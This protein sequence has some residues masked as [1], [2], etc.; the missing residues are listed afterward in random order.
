MR[1]WLK[2]NGPVDNE[3]LE[4]HDKWLCMMWP[5]LHLLRELLSEDG[6]IFVSID[7]HEQHHLRAIMDEIFGAENFV[8]NVAVVS[9]LAG[10]SDQFGFAGAHE[11]C[12]VYAKY[13]AQT[14]LGRFPLDEDKIAEWDQD[15]KG[16]YKPELLQRSSL[17]FSASL[18]YPIFVDDNGNIVVTDEDSY[19]TRSVEY[20]A[21]YPVTRNGK[22][23][24]RWSKRR[25][26]DN[27]DDVF[28]RF[29]NDGTIAIYSKQR[30]QLGDLPTEKPKSVFYKTEYSSR[31]GGQTIATVFF[32]RP[33]GFRYPKAVGL[34]I[35]ILRITTGPD[36]IV[37]DSFAGS[38][39]TAHAVLALNKEDGGNRK[40]ILIECEDYADTITAERVRR[41]IKGVPSA[42][43]KS[44]REGLGGSFT[45]CALGEPISV[46]SMLRGDSLP[47][48]DSLASYLLH[49]ATGISA[50]AGSVLD[51]RR[52]GNDA[53]ESDGFFYE[54]DRVRYHLLYEPDIEWLRGDKG[55]LNHARAKAISESARAMGKSAVVFAPMRYLSQ[56]D[57][58]AMGITFCQLP[59]E[60]T[61]SRAQALEG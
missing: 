8:I 56:S 57:L 16:Y 39:T 40:F 18:H 43:D 21:V 9:N 11:H 3:D 32:D 26:R 54:S 17:T 20:T 34:V 36:D 49:C 61:A 50:D 27:P 37:L 22:G 4:R 42:R 44:L 58:T 12:L 14:V 31:A 30:P 41:V 35:D 59:Y 55:A 33:Q 28:A 46:E 60:L 53:V 51:F 6:A 24:W 47:S 45:Y 15:E 23:I 10:S 5:R 13:R 7:D 52:R 48:Y 38:G 2:E 19:P 29:R 1:Q 25:I